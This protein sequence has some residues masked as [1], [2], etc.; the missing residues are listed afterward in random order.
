MVTRGHEARVTEEDLIPEAGHQ[1]EPG[2]G[3]QLAPHQGLHHLP[4]QLVEAPG[5]E[6]PVEDEQ[7]DEDPEPGP[8][9]VPALPHNRYTLGNDDFSYDFG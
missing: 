6:V 4:G 5:V 2:A 9:Q 8:V 7:G 1:L 3:G